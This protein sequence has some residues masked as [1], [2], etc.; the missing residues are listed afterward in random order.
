VPNGN[1]EVRLEAPETAIECLRIRLCLYPFINLESL[2][3]AKQIP[4]DRI[5]LARMLY[6][7]SI[8]PVDQLRRH[9]W[10]EILL[11]LVDRPRRLIRKITDRT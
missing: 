10:T 9:L 8:G 6:A 11:R 1:T 2:F 7:A 4:I 3:R 5:L